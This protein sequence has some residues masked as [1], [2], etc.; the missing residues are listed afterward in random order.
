MSINFR[1]IF[2]MIFCVCVMFSII[3]LFW[4]GQLRSQFQVLA[5]QQASLAQTQVHDQSVVTDLAR[6][7][8]AHRID[9]D[10]IGRQSDLASQHFSEQLA[11]KEAYLR[12]QVA[13]VTKHAAKE[14]A[15]DREKWK[16]AQADQERLRAE[17]LKLK[18]A[19]L[20][21]DQRTKTAVDE[22]KADAKAAA[23]QLTQ[24]IKN[25]LG[26]LDVR[27]TNMEKQL[28]SVRSD[29]ALIQSAIARN[30]LEVD[31]LRRKGERDYFEFLLDKNRPT[32]VGNLTLTLVKASEDKN[33]PK[34][35]LKAV[36][37]ANHPLNLSDRRALEAMNYFIEA[38]V[39][40]QI[41]IFNATKNSVSGY[42]SAPKKWTGPQG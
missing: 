2:A 31:V 16:A 34:F 37:G 36:D 28:D 30:K 5:S 22:A 8:A 26:T 3:A 32:K 19:L 29:V 35:S 18:Q 15:A 6:D 27:Q 42:V 21:Q 23:A 4:A 9:I 38:G 1:R 33:G 25:T 17:Q 11:Q 13:T 7:V 40:Y 24:P 20:D 10:N 12:E 39:F 14:A 41:V